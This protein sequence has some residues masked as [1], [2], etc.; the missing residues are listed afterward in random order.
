M[1][2]SENYDILAE[3]LTEMVEIVYGQT[4]VDDGTYQKW[5]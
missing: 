1:S 4:L 5:T 2:L 3:L